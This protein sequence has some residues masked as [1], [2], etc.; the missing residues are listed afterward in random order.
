MLSKN[1]LNKSF[2]V[3]PKKEDLTTPQNIHENIKSMQANPFFALPKSFHS[4]ANLLFQELK[5][6]TNKIQFDE[7]T[8]EIILN[9][10]KMKNSNLVDL[11]GDLIRNRKTDNIPE[12]TN[13]LLKVMAKLNIPEE[14]IKNKNRLK[15]YRLFKNAELPIKEY[16]KVI[17]K[18][19]FKAPIPFDIL[20]NSTLKLLSSSLKRN[21]TNK[22]TKKRFKLKPTKKIKWYNAI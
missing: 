7:N 1:V 14:F 13:D 16:K 12:H 5:K 17:E 2:L 18:E 21:K 11:I 22:T 19:S 9:G 6:H 20:D 8:K 15:S 3:E 4:K 10:E